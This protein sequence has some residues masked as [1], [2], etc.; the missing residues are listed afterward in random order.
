MTESGEVILGIPIFG[1]GLLSVAKKEQ[2]QLEIQ[3]KKFW[4]S[5]QMN[6]LKNI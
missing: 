3:G 2:M 5:K 6:L 4:I 1:N